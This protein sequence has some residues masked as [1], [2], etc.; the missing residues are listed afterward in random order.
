MSRSTLEKPTP[1]SAVISFIIPAHNE[2]L[3]IGKCLGS[4]R[5]A[6]E[7]V[8][9]PYEVIVVDDASTDATPR[10]AEEMGVRIMSVEHRKIS[11]VRNE[12]AR[13][14]TGELFFFVDADTQVNERAVNAA[15]A[16]LQSGAAG[17]GCV[18][19]FDGPVPLW[20]RSILSVAVVF[21]RLIRW[22][23]GCFVFCT[24]D[25][26]NAIGG[27][28]ERL[29]A[30]EDIAFCQALKKVGRFV[31]PKPMVTTSGRK[32][33][34]VGPWEV[35]GL[36]LTIA[37]RGPRYESKWVLDILYGRRAQECKKPVNAA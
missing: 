27:F 5:A 19:R 10:I 26:Y 12:G 22:V 33:N 36:V 16:A 18:F 20:G 1:C 14:A 24:R 17:G 2:E 7:K 4:I 28:S 21:A 15:L 9:Q 23:G 37:L 32:L 11:A 6:M 30:G 25:A 13:A 29:S 8:A 3:W 35:L 34:V 31:V